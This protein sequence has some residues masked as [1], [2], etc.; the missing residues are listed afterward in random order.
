MILERIR[1]EMDRLSDRQ[2]M[3]AQYI[4]TEYEE[5]A[6]LTAAKLAE[7]S[8]VSEATVI[9]FA[10][11]MGY[12]RYSDLQKD[13]RTVMRGK[14][15]QMDRFRRTGDL[16]NHSSVMQTVIRSMRADIRSIEQTLVSLHEGELASAVDWIATARRVYVVGTHSEYGIACYFASTLCWIRDQVYLLDET[17]NPSFDAM[18]D[19]G[20]E[21]VI[22]ALSFPPYPAATVRFLEAAVKRGARSL[23][24]TDSPLSPLAK[25]A[26]CSLYPHD[27]KLFFADNSAPTVSLLSVILALVSSQD[28]EGS[29]ARLRNKQKYWEEIGFYHQEK[30]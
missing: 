12:G 6:F 23:A 10:N 17:H 21:D 28:F 18:A 13:L 29:S 4:L 9:R 26:N 1:Q 24:I 11:H 3:V 22:V 7:V 19:M 8:D 14:L 25:R 20:E 27:E 30:N 2:R 16:K 15:S 5:A